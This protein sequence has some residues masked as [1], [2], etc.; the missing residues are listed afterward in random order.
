MDQKI[1]SNG[2]VSV[3]ID[4]DRMTLIADRLAV[5][6][7]RSTVCE[8]VLTELQLPG[9]TKICVRI[10]ENTKGLAS[11]Y[12]YNKIL[13][14]TADLDVF[15]RGFNMGYPMCDFVGAGDGRECADS[16][17][18]AWFNC[19]MANVQ[20]QAVIFGGSAD[21]GYARL[22]QPYVGDNSKRNR[23][24]LIEGPP[25]AKELAVLNDKFLV[26][27][28][29]DVFRNTKL[30]YAATIA[31]P[32]DA[33]AVRTDGAY[34]PSTNLTVPAR[35]D[36]PVLQNSRGHRLDVIINPPQ[37]LVN[38]MRT[39]KYC[40]LFHIL[41][42]CTYTKY[43]FLHG[44]RLDETGIEARRLILHQTPCVSG[45][46]CKDEKCLL[47][48]Q[49]PDRGCAKSGRVCRFPREMFLLGI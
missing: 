36:Y 44:I 1:D 15:V 48:H 19:D 25:F 13:D 3:L 49:C 41:G 28:F 7:L 45:L 29:P 21:N 26:T 22:L 43:I 14:S 35:R 37:S 16:E 46:Q 10:Y 5:H 33:A 38:V 6:H 20:Y 11:A 32:V 24:T 30:P 47:G 31:S 39:T 4:G 9:H 27:R 34:Y 8:Y 40:N 2:F 42:E 17:L 12:C 23:I 18:K